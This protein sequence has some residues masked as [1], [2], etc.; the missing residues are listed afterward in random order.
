MTDAQLCLSSQLYNSLLTESVCFVIDHSQLL[1]SSAKRYKIH[2]YRQMP[3]KHVLLT[4][5]CVQIKHEH[6]QQL[7]SHS[8]QWMTWSG[9]CCRHFSLPSRFSQKYFAVYLACQSAQHPHFLSEDAAPWMGWELLLK[10]SGGESRMASSVVF[11]PLRASSSRAM[12]TKAASTFWASLAEVS[13]E[14]STLLFSARVQASSNKTCLRAS[15][16]DLLPAV[17]KVRSADVIL[18][19]G[20]QHRPTL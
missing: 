15:R 14:A 4:L 3:P 13:K 16:S 8:P 17:K 18:E 9:K 10:I 2:F 12:R 5:K 11:M 1:A 7:D 6:V 20:S 19:V